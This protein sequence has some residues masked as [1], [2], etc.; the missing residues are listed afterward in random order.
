VRYGQKCPGGLFFAD[1]DAGLELVAAA[2]LWVQIATP[3]LCL[4]YRNASL[5]GGTCFN[6]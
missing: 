2:Y 3:D 5:I 1:D 6:A 4:V